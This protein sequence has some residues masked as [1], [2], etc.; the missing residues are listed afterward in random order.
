MKLLYVCLYCGRPVACEIR[1]KKANCEAC[2]GC[3]DNELV[4]IINISCGCHGGG[5][6]ESD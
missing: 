2:M 4:E 5:Q 6:H 3:D 1:G